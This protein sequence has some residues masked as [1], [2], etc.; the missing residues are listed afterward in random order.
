VLGSFLTLLLPK[1]TSNGWQVTV[2]LLL[3]MWRWVVYAVA[4]AVGSPCSPVAARET[5]QQTHQMVGC[6]GS[7]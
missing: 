6:I 5:K 7:L 4:Q 1:Q 2:Q 3:L